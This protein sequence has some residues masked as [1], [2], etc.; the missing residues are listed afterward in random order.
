MPT[1]YSV[2]ASLLI[3]SPGLLPLTGFLTATQGSA[4]VYSTRDLRPELRVGDSVQIRDQVVTVVRAIREDGF[5]VEP[6][7]TMQSAS[8]IKG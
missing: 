3:V 7:I 5:L 1:V 4:N 8:M 2:A 6:A